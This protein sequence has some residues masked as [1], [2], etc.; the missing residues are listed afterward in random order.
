M[1]D[2]LN[3]K[4]GTKELMFLILLVSAIFFF[5]NY[6][7]VGL[8]LFVGAF[9]LYFLPFY[10]FLDSFDLALEEK[11]IFSFFIGL[12]IVSLLVLYLTKII[13]SIR[14]SIIVSFII[15]MGSSLIFRKWYRKKY[16][17]K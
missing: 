3:I 12:G 6:E 14:I 4:F 9:L 11:L 8:R 2:S 13:G 1:S 10:I 17:K 16:T 15:L 5:I 7:L